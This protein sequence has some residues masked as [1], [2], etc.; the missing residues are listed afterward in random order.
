[1]KIIIVI[2]LAILPCKSQLYGQSI[3]NNIQWKVNL[4]LVRDSYGS[5][6]NGDQ[7]VI[8]SEFSVDTSTYIVFDYNEIMRD[9]LISSWC[10]S[11]IETYKNGVDESVILIENELG[12]F[13][14]LADNFAESYNPNG[15]IRVEDEFNFDILPISFLIRKKFTIPLVIE[16]KKLTLC[17]KTTKVRLHYIYKKSD[18]YVAFT[19]VP[20]YIISNWVDISSIK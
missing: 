6:I 7:F 19:N 12:N 1:M 15:K 4:K 17:G 18:K 9:K 3:N 5:I 20:Y 13:T 2:L 8:E 11:N 14:T 16:M 10:D